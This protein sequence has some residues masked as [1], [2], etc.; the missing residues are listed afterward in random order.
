MNRKAMPVSLLALAIVLVWAISAPADARSLVPGTAPAQ[1]STSVKPKQDDPLNTA[2]TAENQNVSVVEDTPKLITL[3]GSDPDL[4]DTLTFSIV[5]S[6]AHGSLSGTGA[7]QTYTPNSNYNGPDSFTF[8]IF[9][10]TD[11][12][13]VATISITVTP[14]NDA[15]TANPQSVNVVEDTPTIIT[16][17]GSDPDGNALTFSIV[18]PPVN[19]T[20]SG[21]GADRTYTPN[22]NYTGPDSFTFKVNDVTTDSN[23]ATVSITVIPVNDAPTANP[24]SVNVVEDTPTIIT[25]TGSDPDAGDTLTFTIVTPP[26]NGTLSPAVGNEAVR[27]YT[28]NPNF[29]GSDSFTFKINDGTTDSNVAT[30]SITVTPV[31]DAPALDLDSGSAGTGF[32][33]THSAGKTAVAIAGASL[34]ITDPDNSGLMGATIK[35]TNLKH[36]GGEVLDATVTGGITKNYDSLTGVLTL[37]GA[38][39]IA[40][41]QTVLK[42][43]TYRIKSDVSTPNTAERSIEVVV[44]DGEAS[45]NTAVSTVKIIAPR[46][47]ITATTTASTT[48][49][50]VGGSA[51]FSITITNHTG[52]NVNLKDIV[53]TSPSQ[54]TQPDNTCSKVLSGELAPGA[55]H[56]FDCLAYG[57]QEGYYH[58]FTVTAKDVELLGEVSAGTQALVKVALPI[59]VQVDPKDNVTTLMKGGNAQFRIVVMNPL[60]TD[61]ANVS[62]AATI[63][64][65]DVG[66]GGYADPVNAPDDCSRSWGTIAEFEE[67]P[68]VCSIPAVTTPFKLI[69]EAKGTHP[70]EGIRTDLAEVEI[71]V[72]DL[73]LEVTANPSVVNAGTP[74][75]VTFNVELHNRSR[76]TVTLTSLTSDRH[77]DLFAAGLTDNT[78]PGIAVAMGENETRT[79]SY[80]QELTVGSAAFVNFVTAGAFYGT[81]NN[82]KSFVVTDAVTVSAPL[83][84]ELTA[85]PSHLVAPGGNT[86]LT[87]QVTNNTAADLTINELIDAISGNLGGVGSCQ[88]PQALS[89]GES[90]T[91]AYPITISGKVVGDVVSRMITVRATGDVA[92]SATVNIAITA[93]IHAEVMLPAVTKL[94]LFGEPYNSACKAMPIMPQISYFGLPDDNWDFYRITLTAPSY[95]KASIKNFMVGVP[96]GVNAGQLVIYGGADCEHLAA[97]GNNG[98]PGLVP[99]RVVS[100]ADVQAEGTYYIAVYVSKGEFFNNKDIYELNVQVTAP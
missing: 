35:I 56:S 69:I 94:S 14:V 80:K 47:N 32:S 43:V 64:Y 66:T 7:G 44:H 11:Y 50:P 46:I 9:D 1:R 2:P 41:Y 91:C 38:A 45:S 26:V 79:C 63:Q 19:G 31:N 34:T 28:P 93:P 23:V 96:G 100:L 39:S 59:V 10:G 86:I 58:S 37:T 18:T 36:S 92:A 29:N 67:K 13:N 87:V 71:S 27:T 73:A 90:Y 40:D 60:S 88:I 25:L 42:S 68:Y 17:T 22:P 81:G 83:D 54:P 8:Q 75:F 72:I 78:C 65:Y 82:T 62:T 61:L 84:V 30:V 16:L 55:S 99:N 97:K 48:A 33:T 49:I 76:E 3:T 21:T 15:P 20:L 24:Q 89:A 53:V 4:G 70:S 74:T 57:M 77:G 52:S 12:S 6:P 85:N 95:L 51:T 98:E 5:A